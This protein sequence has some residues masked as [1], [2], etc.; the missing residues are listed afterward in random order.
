VVTGVAAT[1]LKFSKADTEALTQGLG[2]RRVLVIIDDIDRANPKLLP[3]LLLALRELLDVPRFAFL[4]PFEKAIVAGALVEQHGS[5]GSGERFLEKILDFQITIPESTVEARWLLFSN[6]VEPFVPAG[7]LK[8]MEPIRELLPDNPRR[9]KRMVRMFELIRHEVL[10][11]KIDELDWVSLFL[12]FMLKIESEEFFRRYVSEAVADTEV[13]M[14]ESML[15]GDE[16]QAE[17]SERRIEKALSQAEVV[18][19]ALKGRLKTIAQ[20]WEGERSYFHHA[21]VAYTL[22]IF[23]L[24]DA[25]TWAE[26]DQLIAAWTDP[27]ATIQAERLVSQ[28][29][30]KLSAG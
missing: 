15:R 22:R 18:D 9:I 3:Q 13:R 1:I 12:G 7:A 11:H 29:S 20:R 6:N 21:R 30:E 26:I 8:E 2:T 10:R 27:R 17:A 16:E 5:W 4:V 28:K 25:L 23:D 19:E 14:H 24:P